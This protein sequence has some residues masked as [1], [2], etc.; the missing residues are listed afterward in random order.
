[1]RKT[2]FVVMALL[3]CSVWA[4]GGLPQVE[5]KGNIMV[6]P[7]ED[8][9]PNLDL[10]KFEI[11]N[12]L[13]DMPQKYKHLIGNVYRGEWNNRNRTVF[14]LFLMGYENREI[15]LFIALGNSVSGTTSLLIYCPENKDGYDC[16]FKGVKEGSTQSFARLK[17][18]LKNGLPVLE[19]SGSYAE[20]QEAGVLPKEFFQK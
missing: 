12:G 2:S 17:F 20:F 9:V 19:Q 18:S 10:S 11:G 15:E 4:A 5:A 6:F 14:Y 3:T 7:K 1:M 16:Y 13:G 8:K